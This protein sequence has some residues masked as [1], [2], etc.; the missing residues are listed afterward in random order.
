M[1]NKGDKAKDFTLSSDKGEKITL[2]SFTGKSNVILYFYPKDDT[3]GCTTEAC[4]FRDNF[5]SINKKGTVVL[6]VSPDDIQSHQK[7]ISKQNLNFTLL[8]DPDH[9]VAEMYGAWGE[10]KNYGRVYEGLIRSTFIIGKDG[11]IKEAF[12]NVKATGHVQ[13]VVARLES[14]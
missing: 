10:K 5:A 2:S 7:F 14:L 8:S 9:K 1:L 4:D 13:K 6:G 3:P 12:Y 11:L